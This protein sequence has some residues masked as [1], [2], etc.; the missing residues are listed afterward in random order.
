MNGWYRFWG[1]AGH[2][3]LEKCPVIDDKKVFPCGAYHHAWL[4]TTNPVPLDGT[5][6]RTLCISDIVSC[7]CRSGLSRQI[8]MRN[9]GSYFVYKLK[10]LNDICSGNLA[11]NARYCGMRGMLIIHQ[12]LSYLLASL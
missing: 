11:N 1:A 5:V 9:C 10:G 6:N 3:M 7:Q 12:M 2:R 4:N 8:Q